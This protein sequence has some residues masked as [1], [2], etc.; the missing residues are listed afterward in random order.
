M[1]NLSVTHDPPPFP[2]GMADRYYAAGAA[3]FRQFTGF[4]DNWEILAV[5]ERFSIHIR[6]H[7][8][9]GIA[10]LVLRDRETGGIVVI[11][12][13]SKSRKSMDKDISLYRHQLY[14]YAMYVR[15]KFGV[16]PEKVAFNMF[17]EGYLHEEAFDPDELTRTEDWIEALIGEI[18]AAE[19]SG[20]F[21]PAPNA[22]FCNNLCG[23]S[24]ICSLYSGAKSQEEP[25]A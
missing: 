16:Y 20:T 25:H 15:E 18:L 9:V 12:H 22:Y 21:P 3:Y 24:A 7:L 1:Y 5:E 14:I 10:D 4:G 8:F 6:G 23:F 11:D 19:A 2:R 13:K 17:R